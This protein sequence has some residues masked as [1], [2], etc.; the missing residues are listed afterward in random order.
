[1]TEIIDKSWMGQAVEPRDWDRSELISKPG[2]MVWDADLMDWV[3]MTQPTSRTALTASSP[4]FATVGVAS[5]EAIA[6]NT[7][8]KGLVLVN[9][10]TNNISLGLGTTAVLNSGITLNAGGGVWVMDDYTYTT[11]AI[12]AIAAGASSNLA[13]QELT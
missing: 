9:T 4:T 13:I 11:V 7:G 8:R 6:A 5:A 2:N 12:N 3:R 1:M 10:S